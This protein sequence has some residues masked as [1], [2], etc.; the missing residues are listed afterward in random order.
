MIDKAE[1]EI[2][3]KIINIKEDCFRPKDR[4]GNFMT[5]PLDSYVS[6]IR[7]RLRDYEKVLKE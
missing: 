2:I 3:T 7:E 1:I 6:G 4:N 5:D